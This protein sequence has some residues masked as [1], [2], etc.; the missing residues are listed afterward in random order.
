MKW[1]QE[2]TIIMKQNRRK[3]L[4]GEQENVQLPEL[5]IKDNSQTEKIQDK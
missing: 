3:F 2:S 1:P 5:V 4:P